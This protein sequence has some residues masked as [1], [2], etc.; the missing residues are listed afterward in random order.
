MCIQVE[1]NAGP[2]VQRMRQNGDQSHLVATGGKGNDLKIWDLNS[3][4]Q[5]IFKAKNV[6][7]F[8]NHSL[9]AIFQG[10]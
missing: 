9:L 8:S 1:V 3:T 4:T 7:L 10:I 5:P 2:N 6:R